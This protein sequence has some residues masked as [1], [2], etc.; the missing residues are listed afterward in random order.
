MAA[1]AFSKEALPITSGYLPVDT[2]TNA[3]LFFAFCE[4]IAPLA[5][6]A[7]T[8]LLLWFEGDPGCSGLLNNFLQLGPYFL[9]RRSSNGASLSRNPFVWNRCFGLLFLDSLLGTGF[10]AAPSSVDI[11]RS[12][13]II[14]EHVLVAL[15]SF[16]KASQADFRARPIFL[17]DESHVGKYV[18]RQLC[19]SSQ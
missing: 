9:S 18:P 2:S 12:Q 13:P 15:Q 8:P 7:D 19:A 4:V 16:F 5:A 1:A 3:S 11:P 10:S 17:A 6:L 14:V